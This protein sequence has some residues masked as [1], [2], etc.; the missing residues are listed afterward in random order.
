[1]KKFLL[2]LPLLLVGCFHATWNDKP[3]T[4]QVPDH[5][6]IIA[7]GTNKD[8]NWTC[9]LE[10]YNESLAWIQCDF[11]NQQHHAVP[12]ACIKVA[13]YDNGNGKQVVDSRPVCSGILP[14][15]DSSE[16]FVAFNKEKRVALRAC[17]ELLDLCVML[18]DPILQ[19]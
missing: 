9:S 5:P 12:S 19:P 18:A 10:D 17:G 4:P 8:V 16:R 2:V 3:A 11:E 6:V 14:A 7:R 1:M 13:F 15:L